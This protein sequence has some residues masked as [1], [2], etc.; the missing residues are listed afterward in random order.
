MSD[1]KTKEDI[2]SFINRHWEN[3]FFPDPQR[4]ENS[5]NV[6]D[7]IWDHFKIKNKKEIGPLSIINKV[8]SSDKEMTLDTTIWFSSDVMPLL[9]PK[10]GTDTIDDLEEYFPKHKIFQVLP[11]VVKGQDVCLD[12]DIKLT[13]EN[14]YFYFEPSELLLNLKEED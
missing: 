14:T 2:I 12:Y 1:F 3:R 6:F 13:P 8:G 4:H 11:E 5:L 9:N 7:V 10:I